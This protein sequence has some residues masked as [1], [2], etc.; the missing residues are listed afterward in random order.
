MNWDSMAC[1]FV[2]NT[3]RS[4]DKEWLLREGALDNRGFVRFWLEGS[5]VKIIQGRENR[6]A[7][8]LCAV[9]F[10]LGTFKCSIQDTEI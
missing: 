8:H 1:E 3:G 5:A 7:D 10:R 4:R 9:I 2:L 6:V